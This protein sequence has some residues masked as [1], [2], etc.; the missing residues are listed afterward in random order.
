MNIKK[1]LGFIPPIFFKPIFVISATPNNY[2]VPRRTGQITP[3]SPYNCFSFLRYQVEM[4]SLNFMNYP[5]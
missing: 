2:G 3:R 4:Y 1:L 5:I